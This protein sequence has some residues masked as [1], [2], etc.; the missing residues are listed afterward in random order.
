MGGGDASLIA[1]LAYGALPQEV[2]VVSA[3]EGALLYDSV[4][5]HQPQPALPFG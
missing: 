4:S 3:R 5:P 1:R 2:A